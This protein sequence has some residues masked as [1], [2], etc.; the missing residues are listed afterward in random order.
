MDRQILTKLNTL[1]RARQAV[2]LATD[3]SGGPDRLIIEGDAVDGPLAD[4][5]ASAFRSGKSSAV[6]IEGQGL[7]LNVHLPPPQIVV[8][9]AVHISQVLAQMAGLA[10]FDIRIIDPRT[11]FATPERFDGV[12]LIADWPVDVLKERPLD[13]YTALVAVTHDPKID[14]FPIA[15]ALKV[16]CFYVGALGSRKTHASRVERLKREGLRDADLA[17]IHAPIGLPIGASSPAEIAVAILAEIIAALRG[18]DVSSP[19]GD[20]R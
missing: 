17:K 15:E 4:A 3:L 19:K 18:R 1:R 10:G 12:D 14:D 16:G 7:F 5:I 6:E 9:G 13:A 20:K 11:A 2:I 8:I